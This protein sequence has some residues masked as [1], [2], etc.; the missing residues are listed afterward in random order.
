MA[1][2]QIKRNAAQCEGCGTVLESV[3][4][5]DFKAHE[6]T[7]HIAKMSGTIVRRY[8]FA[9]DG[10]LDYIRRMFGTR[11]DYIELSEYEEQVS[12]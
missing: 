3:H 9:V 5:H 4:R 2:D 10:G 8:Y 1:R 6:C 11:D 12:P 7:Q